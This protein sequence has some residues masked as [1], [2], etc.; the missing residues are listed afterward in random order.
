[1]LG[2]LHPFKGVNLLLDVPVII[3][4]VVVKILA[5]GSAESGPA[6]RWRPCDWRGWSVAGL[7][8]KDASGDAVHPLVD[9]V[10]SVED[11]TESSVELVEFGVNFG[12]VSPSSSREI[13]DAS[14]SR[15]RGTANATQD[16]HGLQIRIRAVKRTCG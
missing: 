4:V 10:Q 2:R 7:N 11:G 16:S 5:T 9:V 13:L 15:G 14:A 6:F 8:G 3:H 1:M 12:K